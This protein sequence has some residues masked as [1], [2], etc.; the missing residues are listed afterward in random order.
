MVQPKHKHAHHNTNYVC[1]VNIILQLW[2]HLQ[3]NVEETCEEPLYKTGLAADVEP[4]LPLLNRKL[5]LELLQASLGNLPKGYEVW[6]FYI[7][8]L[9]ND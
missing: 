4:D 6:Y 2:L 8:A 3:I 5:H 7:W 9:E 1:I